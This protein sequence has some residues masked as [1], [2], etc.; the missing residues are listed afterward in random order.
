MLFLRFSVECWFSPV[1]PSHFSHLNDLLISLAASWLR[2][3]GSSLAIMWALSMRY[4]DSVVALWGLSWSAA[5]GLLV[6]LTGMNPF[7]CIVRQILK[8]RPTRK[9]PISLLQFPSQSR[10]PPFSTSTLDPCSKLI[11]PGR[12]SAPHPHHTPLSTSQPLTGSIYSW[13]NWHTMK[14]KQKPAL[15]TIQTKYFIGFQNKKMSVNLF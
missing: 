10:L 5:C 1:T 2:H 9:S 14:E 12:T 3:S 13:I 8:H 4:R 7:P 11:L 15:P 6:P